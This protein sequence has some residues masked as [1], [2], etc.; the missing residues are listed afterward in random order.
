MSMNNVH[1]KFRCATLR[2]KKAL[3]I[4]RELIP[5]RTTR[6]VF[7]IRLPGPITVSGS[8]VSLTSLGLGHDMTEEYSI[9]L[10]L[11]KYLYYSRR[12]LSLATRATLTLR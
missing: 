2:I 4:F 9:K 1:A 8:N 6:V 10:Q 5:K 12:H 11:Q 3:G 7:G